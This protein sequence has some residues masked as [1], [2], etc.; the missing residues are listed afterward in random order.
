[1][2]ADLPVSRHDADQYICSA[3]NMLRV[4][5]RLLLWGGSACNQDALAAIGVASGLLVFLIATL[6]IGLYFELN[7][8]PRPHCRGAR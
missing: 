3:V 7:Q 8:D 4:L 6:L 5:T 2:L 1:M